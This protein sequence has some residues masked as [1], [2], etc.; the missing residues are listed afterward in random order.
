[1]NTELINH[2]YNLN[3]KVIN[4]DTNALPV[5]IEL[6]KIEKVLADVIKGVYEQAIEEAESY[7]KGE[8]TD[9]GAK[10]QVRNGAT[11]WDFST[12]EEVT[13]LK[14]ELKAKEEELKTLA[15]S[16]VKNLVNADTGELYQLPIEKKGKDSLTIKFL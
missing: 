12:C 6:K 5:Y 10:F 7:G 11:R 15:K 2:I 4:G 3:E 8:H 14:A 16:R 1:M 13:Q 9:H